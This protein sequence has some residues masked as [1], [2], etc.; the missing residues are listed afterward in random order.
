[1]RRSDALGCG[2]PLAPCHPRRCI[3]KACSAV[4]G[5]AL[6]AA[7]LETL[8]S[9]IFWRHSNVTERHNKAVFVRWCKA[10]KSNY[11]QR[12]AQLRHWQLRSSVPRG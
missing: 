6:L 9:A 8:F 7:G 5:H 12:C 4:R 10:N 3:R 1:M 2:V 11:K